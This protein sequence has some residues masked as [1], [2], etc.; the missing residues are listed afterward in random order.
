VRRRVVGA[1]EHQEYPFSLLAERLNLV[2]DPS[3]S[4]LFQVMFA[5]Q[6]TEPST[7]GSISSLVLGE[8]ETAIQFGDLTFRSLNLS[9]RH[10]PFDITLTIAEGETDLD[11]SL[12]YNRDLFD[13]RTAEQML[14]QFRTLLDAVVA[15]PEQAITS[16]NILTTSERNKLLVEWNS[17]ETVSST[18]CSNLKPSARPKPSLSSPKARH[19]LIPSSSHEPT[20]WPVTCATA[21]WHRAM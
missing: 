20:G 3:R 6:Q 14:D 18:N 1:L 5:F 4:P 8:S 17:I 9:E 2:R 12:Q 21:V 15:E 19:S 7:R 13:D 10:V 11:A 16:V